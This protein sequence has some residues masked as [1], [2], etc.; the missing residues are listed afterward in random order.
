MIYAVIEYPFLKGKTGNF[1]IAK[2]AGIYLMPITIAVLFYS[3]TA[4]I[5]HNIL[6]IDIAT[7]V[8]AIAI[9][10]FVSYRV[11]VTKQLPRC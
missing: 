6:A 10:Q 8:A 9:G 2:A 7:F 3:Y 5:G 11:F 1:L 4:A